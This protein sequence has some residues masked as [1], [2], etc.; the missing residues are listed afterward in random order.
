MASSEQ[1]VAITQLDGHLLLV[2]DNPSNRLVITSML[3]KLG[4]KPDVAEDGQQALEAIDSKAYDVVLMDCQMPMMDGYEAT[5]EILARTSRGKQ[6]YI[7]ALTA[8]ALKGDR[9]KCLEVGMNDYLAK[10]ASTQQLLD[11]LQRWAV[12][13]GHAA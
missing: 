4:I 9:E 5:K 3:R 1:K 7:I 13:R 12:A 8:N 11:A 10:P 2:E 6:P